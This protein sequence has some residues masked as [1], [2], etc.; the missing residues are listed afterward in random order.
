MGIQGKSSSLYCYDDGVLRNCYDIH[1]QDILQELERNITTYRISQ[2]E[3]GLVLF[4]NCFDPKSYLKLHAFLFS[5]IYPFA[6]QIRDESIYKSNAPYRDDKTLFCYPSFIY[7][8]LCRYL[9]SMQN[10]VPKIKNREIL[11][12]YLGYYY[13][14]IN[15]VHPFREGNGRT[16]RTFL[17]IVVDSI[18]DFLSMDFEIQYSFWDE[19]DRKKFLEA[20]I[21]CNVTGDSKMLEEC[22]DKV[23]VERKKSKT[24]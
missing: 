1:D 5:D 2:L 4:D 12:Q 22:F 13:G 21:V 19:E 10:D 18:S 24:K 17:E 14:E 11:V 8:Q 16:L 3:A 15:M 9:R 7:G 23:V 6:G 20:S